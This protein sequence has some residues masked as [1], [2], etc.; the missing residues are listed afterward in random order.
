MN[1]FYIFDTKKNYN[2]VYKYKAKSILI[3][4]NFTMH[5]FKVINYIDLY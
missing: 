3:L 1:E 4:N 2:I 5:Y